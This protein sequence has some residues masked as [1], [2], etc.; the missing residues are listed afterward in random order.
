VSRATRDRTAALPYRPGLDGI[1]ALAVALVLLYHGG[2]AW[3]SG[4]F[5]GVDV[6]FVLSGYLITSLLLAER[7]AT[8]GIDLGAFWLRRARRL[9]PAVVVLI[10]VTVT[11]VAIGFT[12]D[13]AR[14]RSDALASLFYVQNWHLILAD[15]SYFD[16]FGRPSPF[17]HLWSL[18]IEEQFYVLWPPLLGAGLLALGRARLAAAV[19]AA[20]LVSVTLMALLYTADDPSR[21]YFGTDTRASALLVGALL[22]F[23][24]PP[25]RDGARTGRGAASVLDAVA[26]LALAALALAAVRAHDYDQW[27]YRGGL[28]AVAV[29]AAALVAPV[30]HPASRV[31]RA[32]GRAPVVW[33]GRRSYGIY[34]WHWPV[35]VFTRPGI[36]LPWSRALLVPLQIGLTVALAAVSYRWVERPFR[37]GQAR[38]AIG[39]WLGQRAPRERLA[40]VGASVLLVLVGAAAIAARP[41]PSQAS[42]PR[43]P[44]HSLAA[45]A[46]PRVPV[47]VRRSAGHGPALAVGASVMLATQ[48]A[49]ERRLGAGTRVDAAV[50]RQPHDVVSRLAAYRAARALP[51]RVVVQ[52]GDN[53]PVWHADLR[54]LRRALRDVPR[55]VLVN[56]RVPRSW[57]AQV[58]TA[59]AAT[60]QSWPAAVLADWHRVSGR[61][62]LLYDGAHPDPAGQRLYARTAARAMCGAARCRAGAMVTARSTRPTESRPRPPTRAAGRPEAPAADRG[63]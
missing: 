58:N 61:P 59:L 30:S 43:L 13:L 29:A 8:G 18:S 10:L 9:L 25:A 48:R 26:L 4:G 47:T 40:A 45:V 34:L 50:G 5:L 1:R 28:V 15:T 27:L 56:V 20:A 2:V 22:A 41:L 51:E 46:A 55:V 39:A 3:M 37:T 53:G 12:A 52:M 36:D 23:A 19:A 44:E 35:M 17:L 63:R 60:V 54:R 14:A 42:A 6:F 16:A 32:L 31:G 57:E 24:W 11:V 49:L 21:V 62:G 33:V 38:R 7:R